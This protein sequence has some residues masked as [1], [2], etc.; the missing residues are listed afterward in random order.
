MK[1]N[2]QR[3]T[4][5]II[6]VLLLAVE[7]L[8]AAFVRDD[9]VRPFVGDVIVVMLVCAFLR[10]FVPYK[11]KLM[12]VYATIFAVTV[13]LLQ[14]FDFVKILGLE[15]NPVISTAL[16]RTFDIKDIVCYIIGGALFFA[17]ETIFRR[18]KP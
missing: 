3:I 18:K 2:K 16:G 9:F 10:I 15:N 6:F 17:A 7:V 13:E 14:Y 5:I 4:Y 1:T 12:P 11:I 8:I